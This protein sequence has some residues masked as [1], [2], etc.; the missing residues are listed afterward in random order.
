MWDTTEIG[1]DADGP[2]PVD[3]L[4]SPIESDVFNLSKVKLVPSVYPGLDF[5]C[6]PEVWRD[7]RL[8]RMMG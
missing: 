1:L 5:L 7:D 2:R 6:I 3:K 4:P 8:M